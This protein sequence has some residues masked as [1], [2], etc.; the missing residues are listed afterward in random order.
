VDWELPMVE[1]NP[2]A[3]PKYDPGDVE[4]GEYR[5]KH[6]LAD[7]STRFV[8][9]LADGLI[10]LTIGV[11]L[12]FVLGSWEYVSTG[13][14][15]PFALLAASNIFGF[16]GFTLLH[17]YFLKLNGQT[18]GKKLTGIRIADLDGGVPDFSR[19]LFLRYLPIS[20]VA[21]I[22]VIGPFLPLIDVLFIF[23]PARRCVHDLIAG[24][25]VLKDR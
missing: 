2:Y 10:G 4:F 13:R 24:T 22:P 16:I 11:P 1:E 23:G 9:S 6:V 14:P 12:M 3:P 17:G 8:S 19:V 7:R 15:A 21:L 20:I 18:L 25:Q 5:G